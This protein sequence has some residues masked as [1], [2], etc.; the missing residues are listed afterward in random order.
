M[1][2]VF[3][4]LFAEKTVFFNWMIL[5]PLLKIFDHIW[6][7]F[8]GGSLFCS[9][10]L[11]IWSYANTTGSMA[12]RLQ[13]LQ[14]EGSGTAIPGLQSKAQKLWY[15]SLVAPRHAGSSWTRDWTHVSL[16]GKRIL[17]HW[18]TREVLNFLLLKTALTIWEGD[19]G[20][21]FPESP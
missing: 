19:G 21:V 10:G 17:Y 8:F 16:T 15:T 2:P 18:T 20:G 13:Q 3:P 4:A 11:Y 12:L 9:T 7:T 14:W 5:A 6:N 1:H